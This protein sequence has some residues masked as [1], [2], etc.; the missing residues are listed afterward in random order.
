[1][2]KISVSGKL[3]PQLRGKALI[4]QAAAI[5]FFIM[6]VTATITSL[7]LF[8]DPAEFVVRKVHVNESNFRPLPPKN[9][10]NESTT[11]NKAVESRAEN[12]AAGLKVPGKMTQHHNDIGKL[13]G[14]FM[15]NKLH[16][17]GAR[18]TTSYDKFDES[19]FFDM[20]G[21]AV[22]EG[23]ASDISKVDPK[24]GFT[25][26]KAKQQPFY[27]RLHEEN[28]ESVTFSMPHN[29]PMDY[30]PSATHD[31]NTV[32]THLIWRCNLSPYI[33]KTHIRKLTHVRVSVYTQKNEFHNN[34]TLPILT[35]DVPAE[36]ATVGYAGPIVKSKR[37]PSFIEKIAQ[38]GP[39][40]VMLCAAGVRKNA[41]W[42][43]PEWIQHHLNVGVDHIFIGV[44]TIDLLPYM[45]EKLAYYIEQ[46]TVVLGCEDE[47]MEDSEI[48]KIRFYNQCLYHA[49]GM[50][51][52]LVNWDIDE[53]WMPPLK[54][55]KANA[56]AL[57]P[58][59][60]Q[61]HVAQHILRQASRV[62]AHTPDEE[63]LL[64]QSPYANT[65]SLIEAVRS[66]QGVNGCS[67]W[68]FQYFPSY[69][70][71]RVN[72]AIKNATHPQE[73]GFYGFPVREDV[74]NF[75]WKKPII[76]TKYAYQASFHLGGSC[77]RASTH[78]MNYASADEKYEAD[79]SNCPMLS[80]TGDA[81]LGRMHHYLSAFRGDEGEVET[82]DY[83]HYDEY[84]Y[85][86]R[87]TVVMQ[88]EALLDKVRA[89]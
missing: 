4:S 16:I 82:K 38:A 77:S 80:E 32:N 72:D 23:A 37:A 21:H 25:Y 8:V 36:T 54:G 20:F 42:Y 73:Q 13:P 60:N 56:I 10:T 1:M 31:I 75:V 48:R 50:S 3:P 78:F 84:T 24:E 62:S 17:L 76:R 43:L 59:T 67:D 65:M 18:L 49:K 2:R 83:P 41:M 46:G 79:F 87:R 11:E 28:A 14:C 66:V 69:S 15:Q 55:D 64:M 35:I 33:S 39:I 45:A 71:A 63:K 27:C 61:S 29:V 30:I 68:C 88:L 52:Y 74:V 7:N 58:G 51:E 53:L 40:G 34:A 89:E 44:D 86:F 22:G 9:E 81:P 6:A 19:V 47:V 85:Q 5:L 57:V 12:A 26:K 70:V